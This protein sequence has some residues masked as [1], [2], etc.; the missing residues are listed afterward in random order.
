MQVSGSAR[1]NGLCGYSEWRS[2]VCPICKKRYKHTIHHAYRV[3]KRLV[4]SWRCA[5]VGNKKAISA[6]EK[7]AKEGSER[8][9]DV[10]AGRF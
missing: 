8:H 6:E 7:P 2:S 3:G 4:C 5:R 10:H 1:G 9:E